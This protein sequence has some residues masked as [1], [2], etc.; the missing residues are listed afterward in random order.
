MTG[1]GIVC[2]ENCPVSPKAIFT[3]VA[4]ETVISGLSAGEAGGN[5]LA[6]SGRALRLG[7]LATGDYYLAVGEARARIRANTGASVSLEPGPGWQTP[8]PGSPVAVQVRLQR[9]YVDPARCTGCGICQHECPVSGQR[10]IRVSA[11]NATREPGH[12][13]LLKGAGSH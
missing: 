5:E 6:V 1:L 9:P 10:A 13:L 2:Q 7:A 11:E 12:S 4:F 3:R 8:P